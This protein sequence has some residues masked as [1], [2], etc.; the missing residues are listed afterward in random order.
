[1][2]FQVGIGSLGGTAFFQVGP[3]TPLQT[4]AMYM[5]INTTK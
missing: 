3:C 5:A 2:S 1:M 4:M